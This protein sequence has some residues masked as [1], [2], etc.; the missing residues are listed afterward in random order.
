MPT[1]LVTSKMSPELRARVEASVAGRRHV[2][3]GRLG[4][5]SIMLLRVVAIGA[6][7]A[8]VAWLV[9]TKRAA[10][11]ETEDLRASLVERWQRASHRL[12]AKQ[13][14]LVLRVK[15]WFK[16]SA[17]KYPGDLVAQALTGA[18]ALAG[19][20]KQ[21]TVYVRGALDD[22]KTGA[23]L[24]QSARE[25]AKDAFVLCLLDPPK[26]RKEKALLGRVR[27]AYSGGDRMQQATGHVARLGDAVVGLPFLA[28][29]WQKQLVDA[30]HYQELER[31]QKSF[32]RAPLEGA[33]RAAQAK[34]LLFAIDE[35]GEASALSELDGERPH[36]VRVGLIEL[37]TGRQLLR[38]R[39]RVD[40]ST[41][42]ET[43]RTEYARGMDGCALALQVL[44]ALAEA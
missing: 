32:E 7:V 9:S 11:R 29:G 8:T 33:R 10:D 18:G 31:L 42:S 35:P 28:D 22:V 20:L 17:G 12:S 14:S 16:R 30:K 41:L 26:V 21:P 38:L 3:S 1:F 23:G 37:E 44:D 36:H 13:R 5:R 6:I 19:A 15:P 40:P 39:R 27:S 4:A 43:S 2:A 34:L 24:E 25:S